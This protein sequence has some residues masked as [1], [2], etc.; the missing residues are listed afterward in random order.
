MTD[1]ALFECAVAAAGLHNAPNALSPIDDQLLFGQRFHLHAISGDWVQG[2]VLSP[3]TG[4]PY[5]TGFV[6]ARYLQP[7]GAAPTHRVASL[8]AP[9]FAQPDI[10][11]RI[12]R[13]LS[14]GAQIHV[15]SH[16]GDFAQI[17]G[18]YMH[19]AHICERSLYAED[20]VSIAE[21][22]MLLPYIWGGKSANGVDCSG[23]VQCALWAAGQDCPRDATDQQR[24]VGK[25]V[26]V[27]SDLSELA[28]GDLIYW[29]GHVGIMMDD[30][31]MLHANAHHMMT[32]IE[33]L[34]EAVKRI[35]TIAAIRRL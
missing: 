32:D 23:L 10:K 29:P 5:Y 2:D 18:G 28:R 1:H 27:K 13:S 8:R 11:G 15:T 25:A 4:A 21:R 17:P 12:Y 6:R 22:Y 26:D 31:W 3:I 33:P 35:G 16:E 20:F 9:I 30:A 7:A 14:L 19:N 24:I 34:S